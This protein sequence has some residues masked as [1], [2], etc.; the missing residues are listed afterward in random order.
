MYGDGKAINYVC[1]EFQVMINFLFVYGV[2]SSAVKQDNFKRYVCRYRRKW[3]KSCCFLKNQR[4]I[5]VFS[6]YIQCFCKKFTQF[7]EKNLLKKKQKFK[8]EQNQNLPYRKIKSSL[9][10]FIEKNVIENFFNK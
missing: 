8:I 5:I 3:K 1:F 7:I 6:M 4:A 2:F 9:K 10:I